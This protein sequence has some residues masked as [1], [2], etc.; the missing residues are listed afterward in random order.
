M[1][2]IYLLDCTL[3]DGGYINDWNFGHESIVSIIEKLGQT[4]IEMIEIG[5]IKGDI[6]NPDKTLFP[7]TDSFKNVIV[8]KIDKVQYIGMLDMSDPVPL[9]RIKNKRN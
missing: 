3:R 5:F 4:G 1:R 7:D 6:Y 9:E 8:N 2:N